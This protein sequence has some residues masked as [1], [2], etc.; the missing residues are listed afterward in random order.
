MNTYQVK[1]TAQTTMCSDYRVRVLIIDAESK[2][3]ARKI[4]EDQ[5]YAATEEFV[6]SVDDMM[7][8]PDPYWNLD[9]IDVEVV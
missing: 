4:A 7:T 9:S 3:D 6:P 8:Y 2:D 1:V 5:Y